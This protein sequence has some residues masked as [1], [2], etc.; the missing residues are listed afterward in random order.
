MR[1]TKLVINEFLIEAFPKQRKNELEIII[2][3]KLPNIN[4]D[5]DAETKGNRICHI[6]IE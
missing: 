5:M 1:E 3:I 4:A 6:V 2:S